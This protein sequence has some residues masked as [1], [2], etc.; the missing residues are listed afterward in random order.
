MTQPKKTNHLVNETSPYLLQHVHNPVDW[1]P[2]GEEA[3]NR[4]K[5]EDKPIILSIGY[6]SCHWC[7]VMERESFENES[8][9]KIMNDFYV[10]IKVDR[11][12]RPDVD[13]IYMD[14]VQAMGVNG[15]WPLN[16]FL[17]PD[18][19][20]FYGGTYFPVPGWVQILMNINTAYKKERQKVEDSA[21]QFVKTISLSETLKYNLNPGEVEFDMLHLDEAFQKFS[22]RFDTEKGG[23]NKAPKFPMPNN[24]LFLMRY[25]H[26]TGNHYALEQLQ[27]TLKSMAF[28]GIYDHVGGGFARYSVDDRWFAPHFEKMLYD[29]GQLISLYSEAYQ[30]TK[31]PLYKEIVYQ[32]IEWLEREMT[33]TE[34]GFYSA[35]DAD[36]EGTEGKFYTW[37]QEDLH[38]LCGDELP[39]ISA[40]YNTTAVGNWEEERN[41]LFRKLSDDELAKQFGLSPDEL[42]TKVKAFNEAALKKR[43]ERIR[44]G[45]DDKILTAWNAIMI[46]GLVDAYRAFGEASFLELAVKNA[47]FIFSKLEKEGLL[48]RTYKNGEA[49][50]IGYLDDYA[51]VIDACL[52]LYQATFDEKWIA[53]AKRLMSYAIDHYYD[54]H[55]RLFYYTSKKSESLVAR[56]KEIFDNVV[57][58][59]NSIMANNLFLL[60]KVLDNE[61]YYKMSTSMLSKVADHIA[62]DVNYLSNWAILMTYLVKPFSEVVIVGPDMTDFAVDLRRYY[63]PNKVLLGTKERSELPLFEGREAKDEKTRIFV[64][65]NKACQLPVESVKEAL[66]LMK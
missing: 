9:A 4:A 44:P 66:E 50:I 19:K 64:C 10:C 30:L 13:Q 14:A 5:S 55:D 6:S 1:Y 52:A 27:L 59:S 42:V 24:W 58:A 36:S 16:V 34:G 63:K 38:D 61:E 33:D 39:L 21:D 62:R 47:D 46:R 15:G 3:L 45:L 22:T 32:T 60:S 57:P 40:Y 7:H 11:E 41:I 56:K 26:L 18:Q 35:L 48:L 8:V 2:W 43:E 20:P 37:T 23:V 17:T 53:H 25:H 28:G 65:Y 31:D 51:L 49:K 29:N 12:E 54:K